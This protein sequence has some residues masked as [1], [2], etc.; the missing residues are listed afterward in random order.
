MIF[1]GNTNDFYTGQDAV[2]QAIYTSL[3]LLQGE[4]WLDQSIGLPLFQHIV[5]QSGTPEHIRG[6]DMLVQ[7]VILGVQGVTSI[8][9][10]SSSYSN[11]TYQIDNAVV[12]T[13]YGAVEIK[14]VTFS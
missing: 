1:G 4:W 14:G 7:E 9:S 2:G 10:F 6:A 3:K 13:Q 11:R 8:T 5:G 12:Q